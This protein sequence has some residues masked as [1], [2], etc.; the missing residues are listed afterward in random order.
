MRR[1]FPSRVCAVLAALLLG[2]LPRPAAARVTVKLTLDGTVRQALV[3]PGKDA[4]TTPSPLVFVFHGSFQTASDMTTLGIASAWP[5]AT[6]VYPQGPARPSSGLGMTVTGWQSVPGEFDDQDVRF[7]D[8]LLDQLITAY[9][10]DP[11]RVYATGFSNGGFFSYVLC[12]L[13]PERFAAFAPVG[14]LGTAL[15][16]A[17]LPRPVL[18][19]HGSA[20]SVISL[21][22]AEW[23]R[24]QLLRLNGCPMEATERTGSLAFFQ[25]CAS[26]Q[27]ILWSV[28][29]GGHDWPRGATATIV[30]FFQGQS[31]AAAP[32]AVVAHPAVDA[33][34]TVAGS[35]RGGFSGD[36]GSATAAQLLLPEAVALDAAGSLLIVDTGNHRI[37]KVGPDGIIQTAVSGKAASSVF[38]KP[39]PDQIPATRAHLLFPEGIAADREGGFF[40]ADT[41]DRLVRKVTAA[42]QISTVAGKTP[43]ANRISLSG[44]GGPGPKAELS[45]PTGLVV[46][47]AGDLFIADT[48]NHRIRKLGRDGN[49]TTIAGTGTPGFS[50]DGGPATQ[51]QLYEPWGLALDS[52][53]DL[54]IA[55]ASNHRIRKMAPDGKISTVAGTGT[56]GLSGDEGPAA[57]AQLNHPLAVAVDSRDNLFIVDQ[58]NYRVRRVGPDGVITTVFGGPS[59]AGGATAAPRYYPAGVA[60]DKAGDLLIADP[61]NHRIWKVAG[62]AAPGLI[63]GQLFP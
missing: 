19:V 47:S 4:A 15:K 46:N 29:S 7:V 6:I 20:D 17:R 60:V 18:I 8:A 50:G 49:I 62:M 34:G 16:W 45:F 11:R 55:D 14:G 26:G 39:D 44:D 21:S 13:R 57:A 59:S 12:T 40:V 35:G 2:F 53:G 54:F 27:P 42:G 52:K 24:N 9:Q 23:S 36:G 51:A 22:L 31:L 38:Q 30:Q 58:L 63:A 33:A 1:G 3:D 48:E 5:E 41:S 32:S 61:L 37:R 28:H 10:V 56:A 25:P 43:V